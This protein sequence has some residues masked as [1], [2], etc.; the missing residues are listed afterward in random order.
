MFMPD[1]RSVA[2]STEHYRDTTFRQKSHATDTCFTIDH[3]RLRISL[4]SMMFKV[5]GAMVL[6]NYFCSGDRGPVRR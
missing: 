4:Q 6:T 5:S 3:N 1:S 2:V